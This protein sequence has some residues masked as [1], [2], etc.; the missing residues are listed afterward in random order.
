MC[1]GC[2]CFSCDLDMLVMIMGYMNY[3]H[4]LWL[5]VA[6]MWTRYGCVLCVN[7]GILFCVTCVICNCYSLFVTQICYICLLCEWFSC[8]VVMFFVWFRCVKLRV[9]Y[10]MI[11][12]CSTCTIVLFGLCRSGM[13][14]CNLY[15]LTVLWLC[16]IRRLRYVV[17]LC[18][19][20]DL[21][22]LW[23]YVLSKFAYII[24]VC[25]V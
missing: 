14:V 16:V 3:Q 20:F 22:V 17:F 6:W 7:R 15:Y 8:V 5:C 21:D 10:V 23:L 4:M 1:H 2:V 24:V 19:L 25:Y 9:I 11:W 12:V 18:Y 13:V